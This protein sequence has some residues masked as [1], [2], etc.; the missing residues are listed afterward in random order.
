[1][2]FRRHRFGRN[3]TQGKTPP[4]PVAI[5]SKPVKPKVKELVAAYK[6]LLNGNVQARVQALY[7]AI[8]WW[9]AAIMKFLSQ[10]PMEASQLVTYEKGNKARALGMQGITED[11]RES[12]LLMALRQYEKIWAAAYQVP[13]VEDYFKRYQAVAIKLAA[14]EAA[15]QVKYNELLVALNVAFLPTGIQFAVQKSDVARQFDGVKT[16]LLSQALAKVL[17][18]KQRAEGLLSVLF[19]EASTVIKAASIERDDQG[20]ATINVQKTLTVVPQLLGSILQFCDGIPR[21]KVF[22]AAPVTLEASVNGAVAA[23]PSRPVADP[24]R[25]RTSH[26]SGARVG[27]VFQAGSAMAELY[28]RLVNQKPW[29]ITDATAG[30]NVSSPLGRLHAM[31]KIGA[32]NHKWTVTISGNTVR[33]ELL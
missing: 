5:V 13:V 32:A 7:D 18:T 14:A 28:T 26:A 11:E 21:A 19:S 8:N 23:K 17:I 6:R 20:R 1:M 2:P 15:L 27:G 12:G 31:V 30:L 10:K 29:S 25:V 3:R 22:R 9:D 4:P 16:I 24:N 33:M